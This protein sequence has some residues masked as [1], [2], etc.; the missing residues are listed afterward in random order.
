M[1]PER[2]EIQKNA[3]APGDVVVC[4]GQIVASRVMDSGWVEHTTVA[5]TRS[6]MWADRLEQLLAEYDA[7]VEHHSLTEDGDI[8]DVVPVLERAASLAGAIRLL[9]ANR[10]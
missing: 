10:T 7:S 5:E 3:H 2:P 4:A 1:Q 9:L 8:D 6:V